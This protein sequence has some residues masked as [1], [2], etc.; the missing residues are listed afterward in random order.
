[1]RAN[2]RH[3]SRAQLRSQRQ[4]LPACAAPG[5]DD[6]VEFSLWQQLQDFARMRVVAGTQLLETGEQ[7]VERIDGAHAMLR[8][9][10]HGL[11]AANVASGTS[12]VTTLPAPITARAPMRTPG[13]MI[14]PPPTQTSAPISIGFPYSSRRRNSASSGCSGGVDLHGGSEQGEAADAHRAH[15]QHHAVEVEEDAFAQ[16][17]VGP[18]VAVERRLHPDGVASGAEEVLENPA[19][20]LYIF[21]SRSIQRL[22]Q[23]ARAISGSDEL[24]IQGVVQLAG[25]H[26]LPFTA[27]AAQY[28]T[29]SLTRR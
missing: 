19:S 20:L 13:R 8:M 11:P 6:D 5:I 18:V 2:R 28:G 21:F 3:G 14:A 4:R 25:E 17:D 15:I 26:L 29:S 27:H 9:A 23:V 24:G 22:A 16:L 10:R 1:M 12:R 7:Q